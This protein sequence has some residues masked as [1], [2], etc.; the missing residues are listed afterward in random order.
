MF[1]YS[2]QAVFR[3]RERDFPE[4]RS[5]SKLQQVEIREAC[6]GTA[7]VEIGKGAFAEAGALKQAP[8]L[9]PRVH[10]VYNGE[11][12]ALFGPPEEGFHSVVS[13]ERNQFGGQR[14]GAP[15]IYRE[16]DDLAGGLD[17][18]GKRLEHGGWPLHMFHDH[19]ERHQVELLAG[20]KF[21]ERRLDSRMQERILVDIIAGI[22][23]DQATATGGEFARQALI[24]RKDI[25]AAADIQPGGSRKDQAGDGGLV[26]I[27][28]REV[29][30]AE[31]CPRA[32]ADGGQ[33]AV[34]AG[35]K[36]PQIGIRKF[37]HLVPARESQ[38]FSTF[39]YPW[40]RDIRSGGRFPGNP[41]A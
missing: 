35:E 18:P 8:Q 4:Q 10:G 29:V 14:N 28:R 37:K 25:A 16:N 22:D 40:L 20:V 41:N 26:A 38:T 17:E 11:G 36:E 12:I 32:A 6:K 5:R 21:L 34:F 7:V 15:L 9:P 2:E 3:I 27:V 24:A 19:A 13:A 30:E 31:A 1:I 39:P 23:A 33:V